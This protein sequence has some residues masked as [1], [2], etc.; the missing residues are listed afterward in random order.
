MSFSAY[1]HALDNALASRSINTVTAWLLKE[2]HTSADDRLL[3]SARVACHID[4]SAG[5]LCHDLLAST[6]C[7]IQSMELQQAT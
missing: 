7:Q 1:M 3:G 5:T 2:G 6:S 4:D